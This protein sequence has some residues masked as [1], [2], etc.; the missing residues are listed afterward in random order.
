MLYLLEEMAD[1]AAR[2]SRHESMMVLVCVR[3]KYDGKSHFVSS[4]T[5]SSKIPVVVSSST[6]DWAHLSEDM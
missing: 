1:P 6:Y 3:A 5:T 2:R 4:A